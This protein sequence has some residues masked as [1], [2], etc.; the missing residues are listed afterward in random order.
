M[1]VPYVQL[2]RQF[3]GLETEIT[4]AVLS[5]LRHG[6]FILGPEVREFETKMAEYIGCR[7]VI[8]VGSGTDA[9]VLALKAH[10]LEPGDEVLTVSHSFFATASSICLAGGVPVFVDI[11]PRTMLMDPEQLAPALTP[12]T[13]GVMPVHLNGFPCDMNAIQAF[14][15]THGLFLVEDAAQAIGCFHD[16]RHVGTFGTGSFSLHPLKILA[17]CGDG[18][19]IST[20]SDEIADQLR[21]LRNIGLRDR[22]HCDFISGNSRLDTIQAAILLVKMKHLETWIEARRAHA[23]AYREAFQ[24]LLE[25]PPEE[26]NSRPVYSSFVVRHDRRDEIL[27]QLGERGV[28][29]KIHYPL[30]THRQKAFLAYQ[31]QSLPQTDA[32]VDRMFSLPVSAELDVDGRQVVIDSLTDILKKWS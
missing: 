14:C 27:K 19:F 11:D 13:K 30:P 23:A 15:E 1:K 7:H 10:G 17:A 8:G 5:V 6:G 32:T 16:G 9:L 26:G 21:M 25:L 28:D 12:K 4:E 24:G 20:D 29:A 22:D 18:G 3:L 2:P 31:G